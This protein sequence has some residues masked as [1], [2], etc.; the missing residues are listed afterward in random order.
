METIAVYWEETIRTYGFN[1][2]EGQT[3]CQM[4]MSPNEVVSWGRSLQRIA[5]AQALFR[6]VWARMENPSHI[7][8]SL[9]CDDDHWE[10]VRTYLENLNDCEIDSGAWTLSQVDT[11]FFQ[12]PH[13]GDRYGI[14]DFT[15]KALAKRQIPL[16]G[17]ICS[18]ASIYLL[19]TRG[20]GEDAK[21]CLSD[22][23]EIPKEKR[24]LSKIGVRP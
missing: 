3:L 13:F 17:A 6:L 11:I 8:F 21:K 5:E 7:K 23:F 18:V 9:L 22:A 1:L 10:K 14:M 16:E 12:G 2:L 4:S 20:L 19:T 15:Y 24:D